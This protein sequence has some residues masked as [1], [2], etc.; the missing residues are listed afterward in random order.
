MFTAVNNIMFGLRIPHLIVYE[1][2]NPLRLFHD[3]LRDDALYAVNVVES[4]DVV[5]SVFNPFHPLGMPSLKL[6]DLLVQT[7]HPRVL[8]RHRLLQLHLQLSQVIIHFLDL[9]ML[10][11]LLMLPA[12]CLQALVSNLRKLLPNMQVHLLGFVYGHP[13]CFGVSLSLGI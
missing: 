10:V 7:R 12:R 13:Y 1:V 11:L 2:F 3:L 8:S 9:L 4:D 6:V 5:D